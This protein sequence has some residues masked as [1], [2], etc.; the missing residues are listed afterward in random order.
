MGAVE[1]TLNEAILVLEDEGRIRLPVEVRESLDLEEGDEI[2]LAWGP[3][4]PEIVLRLAKSP[5]D[6]LRAAAKRRGHALDLDE[7]RRRFEAESPREDL[8]APPDH[9]GGRP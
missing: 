4:K 5:L 2:V 1:K 6:R 8:L 3:G 9:G 7:E